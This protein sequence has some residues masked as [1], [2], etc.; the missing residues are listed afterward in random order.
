MNEANEKLYNLMDRGDEM[1]EYRCINCDWAER[2]EVHEAQ[3][4]AGVLRCPE[5]GADIR[6]YDKVL[7]SLSLYNFLKS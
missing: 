2:L 3:R 6:G 1:G 5:C 4:S 7:K